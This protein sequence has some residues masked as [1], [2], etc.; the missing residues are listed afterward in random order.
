MIATR[1]MELRKRR[2]LM[3]TLVLVTIGIPTVFLA[4]RLLLHAV[5]PKTYGPAGGYDVYTAMVAGVL[6]VFGFIVAATLGVH[7][8]ILGSHRRDVPTP[9]GDRP[10]PTGALPRSDPG[11]PGHHR[12]L[13]GDRLRHRVR[14]VRLRGAD[15]SSAIK[16]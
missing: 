10:F 14:G 11:R 12:A 4:I 5:A 7:R 3:I 16:G 2:G 9:G 6:Y 13:G 15:D 1:F 8:R